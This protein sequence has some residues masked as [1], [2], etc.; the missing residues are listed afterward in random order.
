[1]PID[2]KFID[3]INADIDGAIGAA[4]REELSAFLVESAAGRALH[5]E[6]G[7]VCETLDALEPDPAPPHLR[8]VIV[9][10][11]KASPPAAKSPDFIQMLFATPALKYAATFAAGVVLTLSLVNNGQ[12][13]NS[14]FD[15]MTG[16]V[17]TISDPV[18]SNLL[19]TIAVDKAE[20]AGTVSLRRAGPML[21]LDFDLVAQKQVEIEADYT[22]HK[23]WF[24]GFAQLQSSGTTITAESG[25]VRLKMEGKRRYAVYLHNDG[26]YGAAIS[27]RFI[28][29]GEVIYEAS[30]DY[31]PAQ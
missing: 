22:G 7:K 31:E 29:H 16:F 23:I 21:I 4:D 28:A 9:H 27:L 26:D 14:T 3:L 6:L 5:G 17:G 13:W 18:S 30:L 10:S 19:N 1:M 24:N 8:H 12:I 20:I 25:S 11:I 2:Q 15:D